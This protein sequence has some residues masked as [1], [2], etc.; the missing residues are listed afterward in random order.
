[1]PLIPGQGRSKANGDE[2][3]T[4][5][6]PV[7]LSPLY[8]LHILKQKDAFGIFNMAGNITDEPGTSTGLFIRDMRHLSFWWLSLCDARLKLL[9]SELDRDSV[10]LDSN[11]TN[12]TFS[13]QRGM[14]ISEALIYV[15]RE[16]LI[17][18]EVLLEKVEFFNYGEQP[19]SLSIIIEYDVDFL[20]IFEV[21]GVQ[22]EK[23]GN[24]LPPRVGGK[25]VVLG[26]EGL[27][28]ITRETWI[29]FSKKPEKIAAGH[30]LF[31][32]D[33]GPGETWSCVCSVGAHENKLA[34]GDFGRILEAEQSRIRGMTGQWI[35]VSTSNQRFNSWFDNSRQALSLLVT[36]TGQGIY[37]YAG[38]PWFSTA[39]GRDGIITAFQTLFYQPSIARGVLTY[40]A[41]NQ[42]QQYDSYSDA[43]PG[44]ILHE[45]RNGEMSNTREVPFR[46]YYGSVD[47]TP[48]FLMLAAAYFNRTR[49]ISFIEELWPSLRAA[50]EWI[51]KDGDL[52]GDGFVEY[53]RGE[54]SGI[55][56]QGW[57]DSVNSV[58]HHHGSI[59]EPPIALCEVQGYVYAAWQGMSHLAWVMGDNALSDWL[60]S[61]ADD[62]FRRF[63]ETF[64]VDD[65]GTY[66]LA[67]DRD[68]K[69]CKV[70]TSNAGH[71]LYTKIVPPDR[72]GRVVNQLLGRDMF[73]GWGIRTVG[74]K[75]A[76]YNPIAYHNGSVW[77]HDNAICAAGFANYG[78]YREAETVLKALFDAALHC[79]HKLL[80]ELFCGFERLD[81][82]GIVF[83]P[84][85]CLPQAWA[86]G[87]C[88]MALEAA[89]GL[90]QTESGGFAV[91]NQYCD[92][93][94][95]LKLSTETASANF[96]FSPWDPC[97]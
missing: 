10:L 62:L 44:K 53:V 54:D 40:L 85:A 28:G 17:S 72:A 65:L 71:L 27:D 51:D 35:E 6:L 81:G 90:E 84:T 79:P 8:H 87:A 75:E 92:I 19:A 4:H 77:P 29:E 82:R 50:L 5:R 16:K 97:S 30:A 88:M 43:S 37:P 78:F 63:N 76:L 55:F 13:D 39:F 60:A 74:I 56:T 11:L 52:D 20:D 95:E 46:K 25:Q 58:F 34:E 94:R 32:F 14:E 18:E 70:R 36:D 22:R 91:R 21:R 67:L 57:K 96:L 31:K 49:D 59:A 9:S 41:A 66:A 24:Y 83:F 80:P 64:W 42:A 69:L 3:K 48:L 26:Y 7:Q 61:R 12:M 89:L 2:A 47:S 1:M 15:R 23:R 68:K 38:I 86:A 33:I 45:A 73:S 93:F